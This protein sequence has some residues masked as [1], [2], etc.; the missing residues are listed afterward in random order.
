MRRYASPAAFRA[1]VEAR[2][3]ARPRR[4]GVEAYV[5]RRQA[6]LERVHA[7]TSADRW[8]HRSGMVQIAGRR[9]RCTSAVT[10]VSP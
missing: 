10:R 5:L 9:S 2:L 8:S 6:A 4:L 7:R 1:A 3:R